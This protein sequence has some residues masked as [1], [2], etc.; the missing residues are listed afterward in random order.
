MKDKIE[1][2]K[3]V[4]E[5]SDRNLFKGF[6]KVDHINIKETD[7]EKLF[8]WKTKVW[9]KCEYKKE[10]NDTEEIIYLCTLCDKNCVFRNCPKK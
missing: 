4:D 6:F 2:I 10:K 9:D 8:E 3:V 5:V 1:G 7:L